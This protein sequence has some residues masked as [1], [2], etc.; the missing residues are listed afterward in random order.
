MSEAVVN[1][2]M[3]VLPAFLQSLEA[4]GFIARH[5]NPPEFASVM[6]AAGAPDQA[7][8]AVRLRLADW[9]A[10]FADV[11]TSLEVAS[12]AALAAFSGLRAVQ[13]GNGDMIAVFRA[14]RYVPRAQEALYRLAAKLPPVSDFFVDARL[15][16]DADLKARLAGPARENTGI[17]HDHNEPG[18]RGGFSLYVPEYYTPDRRSPLA[19][20][21]HGGSGHGRGFLWG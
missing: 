6:E 2:I 10:Q 11:K 9:P 18:S 12:D 8:Q 7:L 1:N 17:I 15:R 5:L 3:A 4:L 20:A 13:H 21:V 19:M 16:E 14:L